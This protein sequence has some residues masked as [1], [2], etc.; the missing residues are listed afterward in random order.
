M[1]IVALD[2]GKSK[3]VSYALDPG[4]GEAAF[5]T[6]RTTPEDLG[7]WLRRCRPSHVVMEIGA[8]TG[9]VH[10]LA[11]ASGVRRIDV[12][13]VNHEA[14]RWR[15]VQ[16]KTDRLDAQKLADL[17]VAGQL[18]TVHLPE[19]AVRQWRQLIAYRSSV[20]DRRTAIK[21]H[22]RSI[23]AAV[24]EPM[25]PGARGWTEKGREVLR[26]LARPL[27][28]V[29]PE[30]LWRGEL[31]L[32]LRALD[33]VEEQVTTVEAKLGA[34]EK[35]DAR[36][37]RLQTI[38]GV[39]PRLAEML[40]ALFDD[41]HRFRSGRQVSSYL[42]LVPRQWQSGA[43]DRQGH[44]SR[45]GS[46]LARKLLVEV[47]WMGLRYNPTLRAIYD[48][49][50]GGIATRKKIAI[51]AVAR[52]LAVIAWAMLRDE[53]PWRA[54]PASTPA[55]PQPH[56]RK[57][58]KTTTATTTKQRREALPPRTPPPIQRRGNPRPNAATQG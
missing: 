15:N 24:G 7:R 28:G 26:S 32:E 27:E 5:E 43:T 38:P 50:C 46:R 21:N 19:A 37:A 31:A 18:P 2:L 34:L 49:V 29:G 55:S 1:K 14:W 57:R 51:V 39:G 20:V 4:T 12:A 13:N 11:R 36:V 23:L 52:H 16:R 8:L 6:I 25:P 40:V 48:R 42:G 47:A 54:P 56:P 58:T 9:W 33:A 45:R 3:T 17:A 35:A 10:D 53:T 44:I 41:P 22:I 30:D